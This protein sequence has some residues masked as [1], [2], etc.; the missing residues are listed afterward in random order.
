M[1]HNWGKIAVALLL[2]FSFVLNPILYPFS[3]ESEIT[4]EVAEITNEATAE[5]ALGKDQQVLECPSE[6]PCALEERVLNEGAITYDHDVRRG[7]SYPVVRLESELYRPVNDV[8]DE[9]TRLQLEPISPMEAVDRTAVP[10]ENQ[11]PEVRT[12]V[13]AGSVTVSTNEL[14][15]SNEGK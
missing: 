5:Q 7:Q 4:Y 12:A 9:T 13:Q 1:S 8:E 11:R 2:G 10:V 15:P 6:R 14:K 3:G